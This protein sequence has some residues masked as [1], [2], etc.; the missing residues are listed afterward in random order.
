MKEYKFKSAE[1]FT[2][3][4][5]VRFFDHAFGT[6]E[7]AATGLEESAGL[8]AATTI[9]TGA[10]ATGA[11]AEGLSEDIA[12]RTYKTLVGLERHNHSHK[13]QCKVRNSTA[14]SKEKHFEREQY[15]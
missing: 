3:S 2:F 6:V 8:V 12:T 13:P 9:L 11:E 5:L 4:W 14:C 7:V 15:R 1:L 10:E